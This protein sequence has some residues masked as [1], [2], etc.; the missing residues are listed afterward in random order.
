MEKIEKNVLCQELGQSHICIHLQT[1]K[2]ASHSSM[3]VVQRHESAGAETKYNSRSQRSALT[4]TASLT[5]SSHRAKQRGPDD[6][7]T[8]CGVYS[9]R[10]PKLKELDFFVMGYKPASPLPWMR[11]YLYHI[12][13]PINLPSAPK[14]TLSMFS[15]ADHYANILEKIIQNKGSQCLS[16]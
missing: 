11:H 12:G 6:T 3:D 7:C 10:N 2:L 13:Q 14:G 8:Y 15:Q 4:Y 1:N 16:S 5:P 9:E